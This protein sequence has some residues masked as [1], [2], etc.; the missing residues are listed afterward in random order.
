MYHKK[1]TFRYQAFSFFLFSPFLNVQIEPRVF[2][3]AGAV[4]YIRL[5]PPALGD[6]F[7]VFGTFL[8]IV[9]AHTCLSTHVEVRGPLVGVGSLCVV[10]LGS[11]H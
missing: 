8:F 6:V 10:W 3:H 11:K 9:C 7:T 2:A 4:F 5:H 1:E